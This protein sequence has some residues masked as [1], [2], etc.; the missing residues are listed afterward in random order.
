MKLNTLSE[1]DFASIRKSLRKPMVD[2]DAAIHQIDSML[3]Q[4]KTDPSNL[5]NIAT[6]IVHSY[7][8][9]IQPLKAVKVGIKNLHQAAQSF[10]ADYIGKPQQP[11]A[12]QQ[13][14]P[15]QQQQPQKPVNQTSFKNDPL[16][17]AIKALRTSKQGGAADREALFNAFDEYQKVGGKSDINKFTQLLSAKMR[18]ERSYKESSVQRRK[19]VEGR[20]GTRLG[21][22]DI[23]RCWDCEQRI[24]KWA[25]RCK[26]CTQ[27]INLETAKNIELEK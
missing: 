2:L 1:A 6:N 14:Q 15:Q 24:P 9:A 7:N 17:I 10:N 27:K 19:L 26:Q 23:K 3:N 8:N 5:A 20:P 11:Q 4:T 22:S 12:Q 13:N 16:D 18:L 25:F 21:L